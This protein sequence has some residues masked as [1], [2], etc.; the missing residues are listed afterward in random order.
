MQ[1]L[2]NIIAFY[3]STIFTTAGASNIVALLVSW[4]FGMVRIYF[5][6]SMLA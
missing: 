3:S 1:S 5:Q 2:V 6:S 4:G